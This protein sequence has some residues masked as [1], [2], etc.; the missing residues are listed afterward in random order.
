MGCGSSKAPKCYLELAVNG[1]VI[2]RLVIELRSDK[3]PKTAENFRA[4]CT[5]ENG[6]SYAGSS[7][8]RIVPGFIAQVR[9]MLIY[10]IRVEK[11]LFFSE[12]IMLPWEA[13]SKFGPRRSVI[14][15]TLPFTES[16]IESFSLSSLK[17]FFS[18]L[19]C[20]TRLLSIW[21]DILLLQC[22]EKF[23]N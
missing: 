20:T 11:S 6:N 14:S 23:I 16:V 5:G 18:T 19:C 21:P 4:L 8:H 17:T 15:Q 12:R 2:G 1:G 22:L 10:D 3:V 9:F 7:I 13:V